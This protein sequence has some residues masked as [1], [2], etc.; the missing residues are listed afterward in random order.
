MCV[1]YI[2]RYLIYTYIECTS[3]GSRIFIYENI[4]QKSGLNIHG[5]HFKRK[6]YDDIP[7]QILPYVGVYVMKIDS[8]C[9]MLFMMA[10][11]KFKKKTSLNATETK[12]LLCK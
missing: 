8:L 3:K 1:Q 5:N 6:E 2:F 12:Q 9:I 4:I 7:K 11:L 10:S